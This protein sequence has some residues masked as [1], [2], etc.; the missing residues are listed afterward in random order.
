[1]ARRVNASQAR[2]AFAEAV[3]RAIFGGE[4]TII[5]RHGKDVAAVVSVGDLKILEA[6][7]DRLDLEEARKIMKKP[8]RLLRW[9]KV[10][11]DL[12]L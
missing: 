1:M 6:I 12:G 8:G 7:E 2:A 10:K 11:Q 9:E 3:N 5:R 4:R